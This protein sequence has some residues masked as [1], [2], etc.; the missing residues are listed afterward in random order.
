MRETSR[1]IRE[2]R[3]GKRPRG[4]SLRG[5]MDW[6]RTADRDGVERVTRSIPA[7]RASAA[8]RSAVHP[9]ER[10]IALAGQ[11]LCRDQRDSSS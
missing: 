11:R 7:S 5:A 1:V 8:P 4:R 2:V 3:V 9:A 10:T 6:T